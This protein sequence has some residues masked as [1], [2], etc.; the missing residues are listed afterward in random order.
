MGCPGQA[1]TRPRRNQPSQRCLEDRRAAAARRRPPPICNV[2]PPREA[3]AVMLRNQCATRC[4]SSRERAAIGRSSL[5]LHCATSSAATCANQRPMGRTPACIGRNKMMISRLPCWR[6]APGSNRNY[7]KTGSSRLAAVDSSIR[8]TTERETPLSACTIRPDEIG[9]DGNSS[10]S[11][12]EQLR[13]GAAAT[14]WWST[15]A[16]EEREAAEWVL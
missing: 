6:L 12:P 7:K 14:A 4:T 13:R 9:T 10:K 8:S 2:Q 1:R 16:S 5:G 11:W 3:A 15:A